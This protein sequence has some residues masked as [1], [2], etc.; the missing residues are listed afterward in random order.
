MGW[1]WCCGS[2]WRR[3][4]A[5]CFVMI[6]V[7]GTVILRRRARG[8]PVCDRRRL[9]CVVRLIGSVGLCCS[10][11]SPLCRFRAPIWCR[12]CSSS[13][14]ECGLY[15]YPHRG[16]GAGSAIWW[17]MVRLRGRVSGEASRSG[18]FWRRW[19]GSFVE[20]SWWLMAVCRRAMVAQCLPG[21]RG[22]LSLRMC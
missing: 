21:K 17:C 16:G 13:G 3:V 10:A 20:V 4:V 6:S 11:V 9:V 1:V 19:V 5:W 8:G 2:V 14:V 15:P 7:L 18:L 22:V 12:E